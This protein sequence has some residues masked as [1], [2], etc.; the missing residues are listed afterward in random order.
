M[1]AG[2]KEE[3]PHLTIVRGRRLIY[4]KMAKKSNVYLPNSTVPRKTSIKYYTVNKIKKM[5]LSSES[6]HAQ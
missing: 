5:V 4:R 3:S 6:N 1:F 2:N